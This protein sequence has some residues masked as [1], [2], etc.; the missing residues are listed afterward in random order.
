MGKGNAEEGCVRPRSQ[1]RDG[2]LRKRRCLADSGL[3][4]NTEQQQDVLS[5]PTISWVVRFPSSERCQGEIEV[6]FVNRWRLYGFGIAA[7]IVVVYLLVTVVPSSSLRGRADVTWLPFADPV[8]RFRGD[9]T[10]FELLRD[11]ARN[12]VAGAILTIG[13]LV[14]SVSRSRAVGM[15]AATVLV[16]EAIQAATPYA[17]AADVNDLIWSTLGA[18]LA[19]A[20]ASALSSLRRLR[21]ERATS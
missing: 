11:I 1:L 18:L 17:R 2:V 9:I 13:F 3:E 10:R 7:G 12:M 21:V 15:A 8:S 14:A 5:L 19:V 4:Y 6:S 16:A 20:G